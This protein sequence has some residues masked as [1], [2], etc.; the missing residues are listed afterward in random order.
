MSLQQ[1][2]NYIMFTKFIQN[3]KY[4][5][6]QEKKL[7]VMKILQSFW[8]PSERQEFL[9]KLIIEEKFNSEELDA[10]SNIVGRESHNCNRQEKYNK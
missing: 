6:D 8:H 7:H 4:Q 10:V 1:G 5:K 9:I 3:W 2:T